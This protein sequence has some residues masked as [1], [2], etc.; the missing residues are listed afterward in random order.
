MS[1]G[2]KTGLYVHITDHLQKAKK[3]GRER[4]REKRE[5]Q[6]IAEGKKLVWSKAMI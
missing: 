2:F 3:V 6:Q 4:E 1:S 5:K